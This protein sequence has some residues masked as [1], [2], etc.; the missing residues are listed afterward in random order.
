MT[1]KS[2]ISPSAGRAETRDVASVTAYSFQSGPV[3]LLRLGTG[4]DLLGSLEQYVTAE[5]IHAGWLT[6]LGA[7]KAASLRYYDQNEREYCDFHI[8]Q[9]LEVLSGVGNVSLLDGEPFIHAH[10]VFGDDRG[11]AFGGHVN[12]GCEVWALE[13]KIEELVGEAPIRSL[14]D[15]TGLSLWDGRPG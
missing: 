3:H 13:V 6:F 5:R 11:R 8:H 4:D 14:D 7:V 1:E 2:S 9:R 10:A 12:H 15:V